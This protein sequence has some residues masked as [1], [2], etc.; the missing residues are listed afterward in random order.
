L[1]KP[2]CFGIPSI[3]NFQSTVCTGCSSF[4]G[5][6]E[7]SYKSLMQV[8]DLSIVASE[9]AQHE[10]YRRG[11]EVVPVKVTKK[12]FALTAEQ[13]DVI[14]NTPNKV[15]TYLKSI[16][17][18]GGQLEMH[19]KVGFGDNP[20]DVNKARANYLAYELMSNKKVCRMDL[21]LAFMTELG[22]TKA[23]AYSQVSMIW[24]IFPALEI[25]EI[26]GV[27]MKADRY[28]KQ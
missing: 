23:S 22:W 13:L 28:V 27:F 21:C 1:N 3:F 9:I 12:H 6:Q 11:L 16:W 5:C 26:D 4:K 25:A 2:N 20:F 19:R 10:S 14:D 8:Q 7:S 24:K 15:G 18:R 17:V